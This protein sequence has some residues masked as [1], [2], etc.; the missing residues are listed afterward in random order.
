M[1]YAETSGGLTERGSDVTDR[2][3]FLKAIIAN[4]ADNLTRLVY[5][6]WL[7]EHGEAE[8]AVY[9]RAAVY[10]PRTSTFS[11]PGFLDE[12]YGGETIA[13]HWKSVHTWPMMLTATVTRGFIHT[14]TGPLDTLL[15][16]GPAIVEEHPVE[17][18]SVTDVSLIA[19]VSQ[20]WVSNADWRRINPHSLSAPRYI[21]LASFNDSVLFTIYDRARIARGQ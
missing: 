7:E 12:S 11:P 14:L 10:D 15:E 2:E 9:I 8:R 21:P 13:H 16:F 1:T 20:T 19:G 17:A 18:V 6:D 5:A 3:A 4:P